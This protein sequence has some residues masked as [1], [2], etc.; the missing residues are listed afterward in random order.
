MST[1]EACP[2]GTTFNLQAN[3]CM[4]PFLP[5]TEQ[6]LP[7]TAGGPLSG[8][9]LEVSL[10]SDPT[11]ISEGGEATLV[12]SV[13]QPI[14]QLPGL[15]FAWQVE[16]TQLP[17]ASGPTIKLTYDDL[18]EK[19]QQQPA[20]DVSIKV[21]VSE[22]S[23]SLLPATATAEVHLNCPEGQEEQDGTCLS[24]DELQP[25]SASQEG[26]SPPEESPPEETESANIEVPTE[27]EE[28]IPAEDG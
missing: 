25:D 12:A 11:D 10:K 24:P 6:T 16:D 26:D 27:S 9:Q 21:T 3:Q 17:D 28:E 7:P 19:Y 4:P 1:Q 22:Q 5:P 20:N 18:T 15:S 23:G 13:P 14:S 2:S 8:T